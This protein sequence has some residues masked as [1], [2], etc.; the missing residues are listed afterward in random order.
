M[1]SKPVQYSEIPATGFRKP[2]SSI[3]AVL[4]DLVR[5]VVAPFAAT[6]LEKSQARYRTRRERAANSGV[7]RNIVDSLPVEEKLRLGLYHFMD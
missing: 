3:A 2:E 6:E 1:T 4:A 7:H 5:H